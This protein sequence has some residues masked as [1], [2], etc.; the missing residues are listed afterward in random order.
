MNDKHAVVNSI[1]KQ[2]MLPLF[3]CEDTAI[4]LQVA[5]TLYKAGIRVLEY[6]NRGEAA[7]KN[8]EALIELRRQEM[9]GMLLG[10][11]TVKTPQDAEAFIAAGADFIISPIVNPDVAR[12]ASEANLL[13][14]PGCMTPTE[15]HTA[16]QHGAGI[17][18]V[19]PANVLGPG[20]IS[21]VK[22]VFRGQLFIPTG[23]VEL[24]K[25][26]IDTW[27]KAGVCAVGLGSK[28]ISKEVLARQMYDQ[29]YNDTLK[30]IALVQS[31]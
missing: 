18:K 6:T 11:G 16:Q 27:F 15:I 23:G 28:M 29:L 24:E 20:F 7:L 12:L 4:T 31:V 5:R 3:F 26:N 10:A 17:I 22:D 21:S 13:W 1:L 8:F 19:F 30:A 25:G 14:I 2:R 9:P